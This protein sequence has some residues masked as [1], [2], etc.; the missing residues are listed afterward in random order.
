MRSVAVAI[1]GA[2]PAGASA[3]L[4][5]RQAMPH[6]EILLLDKHSFPRDKACGDAVAAHVL[7]ELRSV[8]IHGLLDDLNPTSVLQ[9]GTSEAS[10]TRPIARPIWGVPRSDFDARL[11][12]AAVARNIELQRQAVRS[13]E[14]HP[15]GVV[16]DNK[17]TADVLIAAD[18]V[19]SVVR[20][21][22]GI[23]PNPAAHMAVAMRGYTPSLTDHA[24]LVAAGKGWPAYAWEFPLGDG[25]SNVGYGTDLGRGRSCSRRELLES[26]EQLMPG[27]TKDAVH[28]RGARI[29]LSTSRPR[30]PDGRVLLV[31]DAASLVNPM[32]GEGIW[33]AVKS[34]LMAGRCATLGAGAGAEYRTALAAAFGKNL[35]HANLVARLAHT[36]SLPSVGTRMTVVDEDFFNDQVAVSIGGGTYSWPTAV[37]ALARS[38]AQRHPGHRITTADYAPPAAG[39]PTRTP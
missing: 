3:A 27:A 15:W 37:R 2:G 17:V 29:P 4:A 12:R 8:G 35:R 38:L 14:V 21:Q 23:R 9:L 25:R 5:A 30:Q 39:R 7:D 18:G 6:A 22:L 16:I 36:G 11:V 26:L 32:S 31:G 24:R 13:V 28:W 34:G 1:V 19:E 20:R 33:Y 10:A